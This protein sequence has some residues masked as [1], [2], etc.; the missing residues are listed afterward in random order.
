MQ[1]VR[2]P[3]VKV[4]GK[5]LTLRDGLEVDGNKAIMRRRDRRGHWE[6]KTLSRIY[7]V[8]GT[9]TQRVIR[10]REGDPN[11]RTAGVFLADLALFVAL[12]TSLLDT[13]WARLFLFEEP[14]GVFALVSST[15]GG[16]VYRVRP[17]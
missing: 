8:S 9:G 15:P 1:L 4:N 12:D 10:A 6:T 16:K 2:Y 11:A 5:T 14:S 7:S 3:Q 13:V 17:Y